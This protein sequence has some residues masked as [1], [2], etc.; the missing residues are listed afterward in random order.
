MKPLDPIDSNGETPDRV[1]LNSHI[2]RRQWLLRLGELAALAGVSG[3]VPDTSVFLVGQENMTSLPPGLY[4]PSADDLVHALS[5]AHHQFSPSL[6]SE[7]DY[8]KPA[9]TP[10]PPQFFSAQ[11]FRIV[12]R[13]VEILLGNVA[14]EPLAQTAQWVDLWF[15][16]SAGVRQAAQKL[17]PMHRALAVAY[18]GEN[19]VRDLES[20][21]PALAG[22]AGIAALQQLSADRHQKE[23][24]E[25]TIAEQTELVR[26]MSTYAPDVLLRKF[27]DLLRAQTIRGYY[28]TAAGIK[29]LDYKG[30]AYYATC[31]GC[32]SAREDCR[33]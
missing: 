1:N 28:T 8:A 31:P 22:R 19:T 7:T 14:P 17:D 18:F 11:E 26:L 32:D 27:F 29:E 2:T 21:D 13:I 6:G 23:F 5:S 12:T 25:L 30:N 24:A 33:E 4:S 10:Y 16:C 9:A 20:A 3:I 15:H